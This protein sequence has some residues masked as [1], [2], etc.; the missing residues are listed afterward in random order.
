MSLDENG[1][2][3]LRSGVPQELLEELRDGIFSETRAGERCLLD[4]PPVRETAKLLKE[5][6][7]RSGHLPAEAVAIQAISFNKTATT[8]WKVAWHQ[9]LMFPFARG[10][11]AVGF[12]LPTLKQGV[13]H[14]RPPVGVLEELLA[15]RLHLDE[16]D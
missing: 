3:I 12:D 5:Q 11:S 1:F 8:N 2:T 9:D 7:V 4:L 16:C 10:V 15:V 14:A 6:L 13:A